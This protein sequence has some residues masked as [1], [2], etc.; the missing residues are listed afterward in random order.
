MQGN[1]FMYNTSI[2]L[3]C[4]YTLFPIETLGFYIYLYTVGFFF[5]FKV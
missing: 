5:T 1:I 3:L 2:R 4:M